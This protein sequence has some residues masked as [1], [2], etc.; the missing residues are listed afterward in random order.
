M[1]RHFVSLQQ[2]AHCFVRGIKVQES[3]EGTL[4][5]PMLC[6]LAVQNLEELNWDVE[7][8]LG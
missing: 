3:V 5:D 2:H 4:F 8:C 6:C 7:G 1:W